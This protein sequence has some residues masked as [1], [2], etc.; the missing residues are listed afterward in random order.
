MASP[1]NEQ[2]NLQ[3]SIFSIEA[4]K[5]L[6]S[7]AMRKGTAFAVKVEGSSSTYLMTC[8]AVVEQS[9]ATSSSKLTCKRFDQSLQGEKHP[10]NPDSEESLKK[11]EFCF[12]PF[13]SPSNLKLISADKLCDKGEMMSLKSACKSFTFSGN[14]FITMSWEFIDDENTYAL[15]KNDPDVGLA[16]RS[17]RGSPVVSIDDLGTVIGVVACSSNEDLELLFLKEN[18]LREIEGRDLLLCSS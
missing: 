15:T 18:A 16:P 11:E 4:S 17:C 14:S 2:E 12:I 1:S 10:I 5:D 6:R 7:P 3:T 9:G 13:E 8:C